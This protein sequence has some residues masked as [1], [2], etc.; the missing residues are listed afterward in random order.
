[1]ATRRA[2]GNGVDTRRRPET[3]TFLATSEFWVSAAAV[4][5]LMFAAYVISDIADP[6]AWRYATWVAI[7]YVVS[8]GLA[9]AGSQRSY[10]EVRQREGR[11]DDASTDGANGVYTRSDRV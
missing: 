2:S 3:K 1:M 6:T 9:K 7:A 8:R 4:A 11:D 10:D 5:A